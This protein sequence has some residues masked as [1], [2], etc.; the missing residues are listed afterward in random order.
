MARKTGFDKDTFNEYRR[1]KSLGLTDAAIARQWGVSPS[2]LY[3]AKTG[4]TKRISAKTQR[5]ATRPKPDAQRFDRRI[6]IDVAE[7]ITK[8][9]YEEL[10]R[11]STAGRTPRTQKLARE[12]LAELDSSDLTIEEL[13]RL[14][15]DRPT[16]YRSYK[17]PK[18]GEV[19][20]VRLLLGRTKGDDAQAIIRKQLR[21]KGL[22][23]SDASY[24]DFG[25]YGGV[26]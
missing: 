11:L 8:I 3:N 7:D 23:F 25:G 22:E 18:T 10:Q 16:Y 14:T 13:Q 15:F 20:K 5:A 2:T 12:R 21:E 24:I 9:T 19:K 17:D 6:G 1:L 26:A 4:R